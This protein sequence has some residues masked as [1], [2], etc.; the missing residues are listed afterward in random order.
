M[1]T[2]RIFV[3]DDDDNDELLAY[4]TEVA[5]STVLP[6]EDVIVEK[7]LSNMDLTKWFYSNNDADRTMVRF[8]P[9]MGCL[10][11]MT[12]SDDFPF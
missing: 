2:K 12:L 6:E 4:L 10:V 7:S 11:S 5:T 1:S 8:Y 9:N 3:P